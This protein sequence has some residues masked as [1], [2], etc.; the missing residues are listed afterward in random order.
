MLCGNVAREHFQMVC[1]SQKTTKYR[2]IIAPLRQDEFSE[3][4]EAQFTLPIE[5]RQLQVVRN[6]PR[7]S[8]FRFL[9]P[10]PYGFKWKRLKQ[11]R[12]CHSS[13]PPSLLLIEKELPNPVHY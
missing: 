13:E 5:K 1:R 12:T 8:D 10:A 7:P 2:L 11:A 4:R 9:Q 6:R 3:R